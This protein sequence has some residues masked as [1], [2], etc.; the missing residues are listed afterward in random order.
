MAQAPRHDSH[1]L[2]S[3]AR[4]LG[5][6]FEDVALLRLA[7][8]HSSYASENPGV[9]GVSNERLEFLGDAVVGVV[10]AERAYIGLAALGEGHL[11][12]WKAA[13]V[14]N[15]TLARVARSLDLG[16]FMLM[17]RGEDASGGRERTS[18]LAAL[19]EA[20]AGAVFLDQGFP[21]ARGFVVRSLSA[22]MDAIPDPAPPRNAKSQLQETLQSQGMEPPTYHIVGMEG[23]DHARTY[24]AEVLVAGEPLAQGSGPR[25][26]TAEREAAQRALERLAG[27]QVL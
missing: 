20:L 18:N 13:L 4:S 11:S 5:V 16:R 14:Q 15:E 1:D 22:E 10:M 21:A 25:K 19:F 3:L 26:A 12:S 2:D 17:G 9:D 8:T 24:T 23:A 7:F 6:P 27:E